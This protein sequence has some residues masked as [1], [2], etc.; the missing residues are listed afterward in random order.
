[1]VLDVG[2]GGAAALGGRRLR[3]IVEQLLLDVRL[4]REDRA[5]RDGDVVPLASVVC[6]WECW[7]GSR[8]V[9]ERVEALVAQSRL[10]LAR[11]AILGEAVVDGLEQALV[12]CLDQQRTDE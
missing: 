11:H 7:L 12:S 9:E 5:R 3:V 2:S 6:V 4:R 8:D 1:M 10:Q